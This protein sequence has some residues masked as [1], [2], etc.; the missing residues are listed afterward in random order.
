MLLFPYNFIKLFLQTDGSHRVDVLTCVNVFG[1]V[2]RESGRAS[3]GEVD[4]TEAE[5]AVEETTAGRGRTPATP[6][7]P[8]ARTRVLTHRRTTSVAHRP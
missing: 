3:G 2:S 5:E 4:T 8:A 7:V 6:A 1:Q